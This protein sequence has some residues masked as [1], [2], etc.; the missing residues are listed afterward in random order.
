MPRFDQSAGVLLLAA[1]VVVPLLGCKQSAVRPDLRGNDPASR[2]PALAQAAEQ[3]DDRSLSELVYALG[4]DDAAV[5]LF[6]IRA[7]K[8]RTGQDL[9]YRYYAPQEQRDQARQRW[10]DYLK[11]PSPPQAAGP[12]GPSQ[13]P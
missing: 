4:D 9:G 12:S 13:T 1:A 11:D 7:L 8:Q 5:R 3:D 10:H 6:A 2:I